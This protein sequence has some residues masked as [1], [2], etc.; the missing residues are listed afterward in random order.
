MTN[1]THQR[2]AA[3]A[4]ALFLSTGGGTEAADLGGKQRQ[5][6]PPPPREETRYDDPRSAAPIWQGLYLG[7]SAGYG[8]GDS[9]HF[10][11]RNDDH[12]T[13]SNELTGGLGSI[14]AGYNWVSPGGFLYGIEGDLGL[15]DLSADDKVIFD[16]HVWKA[17][18]G[19]FWGTLRARAGWLW[20]NTLLYATGGLAITEVNEVGIGD[21]DGQ[22]ATNRDVRSGWVLG[23]GIEHAFAPGLTAKLEYLHMD[24]GRY[25]GLSE[26]QERYYF[27]SKIDL[28]RT[29]I[30]MKF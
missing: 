13:A 21:A 22:T 6:A 8:W 19:P 18:Y 12:G 30:N 5:T 7:L 15:M 29:G 10:Y 26:N 4:A 1:T 3:A 11:D 27:D 24:F 20:G 28:I 23:G 25:D 16:G 9:E 17:E 2:I 14:T